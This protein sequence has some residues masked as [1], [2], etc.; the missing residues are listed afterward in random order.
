MKGS[1][2]ISLL[3]Y[4][5]PQGYVDIR[6]GFYSKYPVPGYGSYNNCLYYQELGMEKYRKL[7]S[8]EKATEEGKDRNAPYRAVILT[9]TMKSTWCVPVGNDTTI[10]TVLVKGNLYG[11]TEEYNQ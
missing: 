7:R 9:L 4:T 5:I 10:W 8:Y 2:G 3:V 1:I 6:Y 11:W